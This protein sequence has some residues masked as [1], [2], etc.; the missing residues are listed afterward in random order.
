MAVSIN[1]HD[2]WSRRRW[3]GSPHFFAGAL[4]LMFSASMVAAQTAG[5]DPLDMTAAV[6]AAVATHP[7]V[8]GAG[9]QVEQ[10]SAGV[11]AAR[12]A[13]GPQIT[14][15]IENQISAHRNSSYDSRNVYTARVS[16][17]QMVYDFGRVA[18]TVDRAESGVRASTAQVE[19]VTDE[20]I[21][22]TAQAWVDAHLQQILVQITRDQLSAITSITALVAERVA[23]GATSRSDV[24]QANSRVDAVRS[25]LLG[26]EADA[27]RARLALMHLTG[28][29]APVAI[30]GD[31]PLMLQEGG[32]RDGGEADTPAVRLANAHRDEARAD[33]DIA[34]AERMPTMSLD[35]SLGYA[36][37][38][39]SRLYGEHRTTGQ[40]GLNISMSLYQ[41]GGAQARERGA[42]Y[43]LRAYEDG[44][45]QAW[46]EALQGYADAKAQVDGWV[47]RAP[48]LQTRVNS[49][50]ETRELYRQQYLHLGTR[51]LLD[52]LNAEQ[53]YFGARVDQAQGAHMQYRLALQCL[54]Y[55]DRLRSA[56]GL[57]DADP[58]VGSV[59]IDGDG[60]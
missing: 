40:I 30:T 37:T 3:T 44:V 14:G 28:R 41:G 53:E 51:S 50:N 2:G 5:N 15:G 17:S 52:L 24:E 22:N 29:T 33:L 8:R 10:A 32:C 58:A 45:R 23:A 42:A 36:L 38:N 1:D 56:F 49:I 27:L 19:L 25:Q 4:W 13:Y 26:V 20:V 57:E 48:V 55:S 11:D 21:L 7:S 9:A 39:G 6:H 31:I 43:Q 46:L 35:G 12:A 60:Q 16:G 59:A 18:A 34:R 47:Q 54:Y